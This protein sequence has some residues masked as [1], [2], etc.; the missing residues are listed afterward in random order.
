MNRYIGGDELLWIAAVLMFV[1]LFLT[2]VA[3]FVR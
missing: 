3:P 1:A 2:L